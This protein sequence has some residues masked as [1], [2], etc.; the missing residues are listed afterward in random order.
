MGLALFTLIGFPAIGMVLIRAF[1]EEPVTIM[2][3]YSVALWKQLAVGVPLGLVLGFAA[4]GI[5]SM[6]FMESIRSKYSKLI[7]KFGLGWNEILFVSFCAGFGEEL[8]FRGSLQYLLGIWTTAIIF[9]ALH[10]YINPR[11]WRISVYG[12]FMTLAIASLG[13]AT[14]HIGI[15]SAVVAHTIIDII[16]FRFL[17]NKGEKLLAEEKE[18]NHNPWD[19][20]DGGNSEEKSEIHEYT[21]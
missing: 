21:H 16:L 13:Y 5:V 1:T 10:G 14:E 9:V 2:G 15:W 12:L 17:V 6:P 18:A 19:D 4:W 20:L 7:A 8:L 3:R 11:D